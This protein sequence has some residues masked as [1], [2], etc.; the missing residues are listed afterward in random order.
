MSS[1][2]VYFSNMYLLLV[3]RVISS[4]ES[5]HTYELRRKSFMWVKMLDLGWKPIRS[6][7]VKLVTT[8][9]F[10]VQ[11]FF[12]LN[13]GCHQRRLEHYLATGFLVEEDFTTDVCVALCSIC[14]NK[15]GHYFLTVCKD[16]L[17]AWFESGDVCDSFPMTATADNLFK[18]LWG[19]EEWIKVVLILQPLSSTRGFPILSGT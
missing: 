3:V 4:K 15:W 16:R 14:N 1:F 6:N 19:K 11:S 13:R 5:R 17:V 8:N 18:L 12:H 10:D 9:L 2:F 7:L